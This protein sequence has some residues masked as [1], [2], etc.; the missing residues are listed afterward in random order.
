VI[1]HG[2]THVHRLDH[3]WPDAPNLTELETYAMG[4]ANRWVLASIDPSSPAVFAFS[5]VVAK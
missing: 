4:D 3:P 5:T 1:V 2:D